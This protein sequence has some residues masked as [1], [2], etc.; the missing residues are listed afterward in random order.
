MARIFY[1]SG[2]GNSLAIAKRLAE[3]LEAR[4]CSIPAYLEHPYAVPDAVVGFV[5]PVHCTELPPLVERFLQTVR[6]GPGTEY[7]FGVV[8]AGSVTGDALGGSGQHH[9]QTAPA[10]AGD[11]RRLP[12]PAA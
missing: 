5:S 7:L 1:F 3:G 10:A 11:V 9:R 2:T 6:F 4:L 8:D 12:D